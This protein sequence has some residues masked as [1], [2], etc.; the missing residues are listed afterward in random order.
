M[1]YK[2]HEHKSMA[3][4]TPGGNR[5]ALINSFRGHREKIRVDQGCWIKTDDSWVRSYKK[6]DV[7]GVLLSMK[8]EIKR[9]KNQV[10]VKAA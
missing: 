3:P 6:E 9:L 4:Y 2:K 1:K 5:T 7:E 8:N 10:S